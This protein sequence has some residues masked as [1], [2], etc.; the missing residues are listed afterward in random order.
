MAGSTRSRSNASSIPN[1]AFFIPACSKQP[2][3]ALPKISVSRGATPNSLRPPTIRSTNATPNSRSDSPTTSIPTS[4]IPVA[5]LKR[6]LCSQ[7]VGR[8]SLPP[9]GRDLPKPRSSPET[10]AKCQSRPTHLQHDR[11]KYR[12]R[13]E[14][15]DS[16]PP[17]PPCV[18]VRTRR[19][20]G[21]SRLRFRERS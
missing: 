1:P 9:S 15:H 2:D 20:D 5:L 19:F 18:R 11:R 7:N 13:G 6:S 3:A 16:S 4:S 12:D 21:L 10:Y 17:T 8:E 14:P